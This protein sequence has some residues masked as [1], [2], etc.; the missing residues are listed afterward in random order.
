MN[1]PHCP[2]CGKVF[3]LVD[4]I[5][6]N[7]PWKHKC[8][9]CGQLLTTNKLG[10]TIYIFAY[11]IGLLIAGV[12]IYMEERGFWETKKSLTFFAVCLL[13]LIPI[14]YWIRKYIKIIPKPDKT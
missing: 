9:A 8:S 2:N 14:S 1:K 3:G 13:C 10:T 12:A 6:I 11:V 7:Y 5:R 4:E